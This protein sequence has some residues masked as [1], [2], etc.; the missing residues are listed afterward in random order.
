MPFLRGSLLIWD[1]QTPK[2]GLHS[3]YDTVA[4]SVN[5]QREVLLPSCVSPYLSQYTKRTKL[6]MSPV[7]SLLK[8]AY[9]KESLV[10]N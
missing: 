2:E 3:C 10:S 6:R 7:D 5:H 1:Y 9:S 4:I 8:V